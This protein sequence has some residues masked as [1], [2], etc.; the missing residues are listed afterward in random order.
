MQA[1]RLWPF[2]RVLLVSV[3]WILFCV[4]L[5][6][7]WLLFQFRGVSDSSSAGSGGIGAGSF[8]VN[9]F[10]LLIPLGP[11]IVLFVA[12]LIARSAR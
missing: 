12:W 11:P 7:A 5:P 3:G 2:V 8:S 10:M 1:L 4:L 9:V 6:S